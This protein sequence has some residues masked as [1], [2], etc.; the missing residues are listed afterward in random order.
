M[1]QDINIFLYTKKAQLQLDFLIQDLISLDI[2][3]SSLSLII[4]VISVL[5]NTFVKKGGTPMWIYSPYITKNGR[6]IYASSYGLK[7]FKFW[8]DEDK[9]RKK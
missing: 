7:V 2:L 9:I 1:Y 5:G 8:I 3:N 4:Y 6:R